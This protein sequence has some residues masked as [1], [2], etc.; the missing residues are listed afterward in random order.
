LNTAE[1]IF[2]SIAALTSPAEL[3]WIEEKLKTDAKGISLA[4]VMVPRFIAKKSIENELST[5]QG[6]NWKNASLDQLVRV[7]LLMHLAEKE[8]GKSRIETLF[9]T[10]EM[11]ELVALYRAIPALKTPEIWLQRATDAVRSNMGPVFDAIA[12]GNPY[13]QTY[14]SELAWNQLVLKCIFNDK[15]IHLIIGLDERANQ[16]LADTLADFAHERWAAG[17]RVPSQV[18]RLLRNFKTESIE[19][20]LG[21]LSKSEDVN[22]RKAAELIQNNSPLEAWRELEQAEPIYNA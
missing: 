10:A 12:F 2:Q 6:W 22:D 7:Y 1:L 3:A 11:N 9:D 15:P 13:P 21:K 19:E 17:R 14:F 18:W 5:L 8:E 4:F 16:A 20:D